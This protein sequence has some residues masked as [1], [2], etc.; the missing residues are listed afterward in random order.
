MHG[1]G[2][3]GVIVQFF[4]DSDVTT[5]FSVKNYPQD[6]ILNKIKETFVFG[7]F[8]SQLLQ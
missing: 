3:N 6:H 2:E 8:L 1:F 4:A 7:H 5:L